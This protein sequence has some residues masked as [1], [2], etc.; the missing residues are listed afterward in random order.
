M[1]DPHPYCNGLND[2]Q[3]LKRELRK[4]S[5]KISE[6]QST[7]VER[8]QILEMERT[9][10]D[11]KNH[12]SKICNLVIALECG[13]DEA[14]CRRRVQRIFTMLNLLRKEIDLADAATTL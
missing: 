14:K 3:W 11:W 5:V 13:T 8:N 10:V 4:T 6:M 12:L 9:V 7:F 1:V 2:G